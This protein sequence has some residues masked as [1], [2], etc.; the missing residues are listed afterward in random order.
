MEKLKVLMAESQ[1]VLIFSQYTSFLGLIKEQVEAEKWK[2]CYLDGQTKDRAGQVDIFQNNEE[3]KIF[4]ISLKAGGVGLNLTKA[5]YVFIMDPWWNPAIENQA[6]DRAYRI[7]QKNT[8]VAQRLICRK[9]VEEK[10]LKMQQTK[11]YLADSIIEEDDGFSAKMTVED[12]R[13]LLD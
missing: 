1:K 12:L 13:S 6:I 7:G 3:F 2:Y 10:V 11:K 9:T 8:V 4:L 5:E